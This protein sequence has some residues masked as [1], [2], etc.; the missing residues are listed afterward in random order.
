MHRLQRL[1]GQVFLRRNQAGKIA[2]DQKDDRRYQHRQVLRMRRLRG[3]LP[4]RCHGDEADLSIN[5]R[6]NE[7]GRDGPLFNCNRLPN[8]RLS[9]R[10]PLHVLLHNQASAFHS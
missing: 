6:K 8:R 3:R 7:G 1:R 2:G 9:R 10:L 5:L 4:I